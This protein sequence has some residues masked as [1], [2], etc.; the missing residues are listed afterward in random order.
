MVAGMG[1]HN[2]FGWGAGDSITLLLAQ[3]LRK[4]IGNTRDYHH[5]LEVDVRLYSLYSAITLLP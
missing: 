1:K 2:R 5:R 4:G 3:I